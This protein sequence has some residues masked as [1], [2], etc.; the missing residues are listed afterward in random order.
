M[1]LY[2][3]FILDDFFECPL[4]GATEEGR[5]KEFQTKELGQFFQSFKVG[6]KVVFN[7][8]LQLEDGVYPVYS[9]CKKCRAW[10]DASVVIEDG[11]FIGLSAFEARTQE[12]KFKEIRGG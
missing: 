7:E 4:C 11:K 6:E 3:A 9:S 10:I 2:D 1:G 12:E 5:I 8:C